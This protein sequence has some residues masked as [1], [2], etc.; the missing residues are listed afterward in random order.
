MDR[1]D[2]G[3]GECRGVCL[4]DVAAHEGDPAEGELECDEAHGCAGES[5]GGAVQGLLLAVVLTGLHEAHGEEGAERGH[6]DDDD[7]EA[8]VAPEGVAGGAE[9]AEDRAEDELD[10]GGVERGGREDAGARGGG[11]A[12]CGLCRCVGREEFYWA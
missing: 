11:A 3:L 8:G 1:A 5:A 12:R 2:E 10:D 9:V 7:G 6:D 4:A